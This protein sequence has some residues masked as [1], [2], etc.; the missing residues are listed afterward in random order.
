MHVFLSVENVS[1]A[2]SV[3]MKSG[4]ASVVIE[5]GNLVAGLVSG[6]GDGVV[7]NISVN[8][9]GAISTVIRDSDTHQSPEV[10]RDNRSELSIRDDISHDLLRS[11][12][13]EIKTLRIQMGHAT[14]VDFDGEDDQ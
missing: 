13:R 12:F 11:I 8:N 1:N 7:R 4:C 3:F 9:A 10:Y 14:E 2:T 5:G 6:E